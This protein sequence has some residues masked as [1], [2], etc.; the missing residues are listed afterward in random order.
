MTTPE[1]QGTPS[2]VNPLVTKM[3]K[4]AKRIC[5]ECDEQATVGYWCSV[6]KVAYGKDGADQEPP[7]TTG[8]ECHPQHL[9]GYCCDFGAAIDHP[10]HCGHDFRACS[11][12]DDPDANPT[13]S[14]PV[15]GNA[16]AV[17]GA[18]RRAIKEFYPRDEAQNLTAEYTQKAI[19]GN[20]DQMLSVSM[21]YADFDLSYG[22]GS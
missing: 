13:V 11:D 2:K 10:E 20:Y 12:R 4:A 21:E 18:V 15:D 6:H 9:G 14:G 16:F 1:N 22:G 19:A 17:M 5:I 8:S 3:I 7:T